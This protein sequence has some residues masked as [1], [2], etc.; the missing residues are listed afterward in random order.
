MNCDGLGTVRNMLKSCDQ[1][2]FPNGKRLPALLGRLLDIDGLRNPIVQ[3][4]VEP[5]PLV[6]PA[7]ALHLALLEI[8]ARDVQI[9]RQS[10]LVVTLRDNRH[11]SLRRPTQQYL[12]GR[13]AM[14]LGDLLDGG[15]IQE[16]GGVLGA[17]HV[18]FEEGLG[19]ER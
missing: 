16:Q 9:L 6:Q 1:P 15:V 10:P 19:T 13:L 7:N 17:L 8:P 2:A 4:I 12:R 18:E 5:Q 14:L 3:R 11:V